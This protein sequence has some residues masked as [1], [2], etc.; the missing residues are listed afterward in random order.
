[1]G[2]PLAFSHRDHYC[3][4]STTNTLPPK[5]SVLSWRPD[6][7]VLGFSQA[8]AAQL[9]GSSDT[10]AVWT[11]EVEKIPMGF[12][13]WK[14]RLSNRSDSVLQWKA[15]FI[16]T[17]YCIAKFLV[18]HWRSSPGTE[19]RL[20]FPLVLL[21]CSAPASPLCEDS[22]SWEALSTERETLTRTTLIS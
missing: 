20:W 13:L 3:S 16:L 12:V 21:I 2:Q 8:L 7:Q 10:L 15:R 1:M 4:C 6:S 17:T 22:H 11:V 5:P 14:K 18:C 19:K 9:N